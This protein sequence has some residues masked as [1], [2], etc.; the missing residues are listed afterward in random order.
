[1]A[2]ISPAARSKREAKSAHAPAR[3]VAKSS[4]LLEMQRRNIYA[5]EVDSISRREALSARDRNLSE[6]GQGTRHFKN[7]TVRI[8]IAADNRLKWQRVQLFGSLPDDASNH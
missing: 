8:R 7:E 5:R 3:R 4:S 1:V 6:C 2:I